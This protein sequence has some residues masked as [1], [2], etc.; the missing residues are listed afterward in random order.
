M[1]IERQ[2][3][4]RYVDSW[5][6]E[7]AK[8]MTS[9]RMAELLVAALAVMGEHGRGIL[10]DITLEAVCGRV[11][12]NAQRAHPCLGAFHAQMTTVTDAQLALTATAPV[13]ELHAATRLVLVDLLRVLSNFTGGVLTPR[14]YEKL[15]AVGAP[16]GAGPRPSNLGKGG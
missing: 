15:G 5:L 1:E 14:L 9:P 8:P 6:E 11:L 7:R 4:E 2:Q 3:H 12:S 10:G 13:E 16:E